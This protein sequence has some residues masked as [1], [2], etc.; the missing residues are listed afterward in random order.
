MPNRRRL[1]K[2]TLSL[3]ASFALTL[4]GCASISELLNPDPSTP[5]TQAQPEQ[6]SLAN[7]PTDPAQT[8]SQ[9]AKASEFSEVEMVWEISQQPVD[10]YL[11]RYGFSRD[12]LDKEI[13]VST[14]V[15]NTASDPQFGT[16]YKY[17]LKGIPRNESVFVSIAAENEGEL[18]APSEVFEVPPE[19]D[20]APQ[21]TPAG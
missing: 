20:P 9:A 1:H 13:R 16:V 7:S 5:T 8:S 14:Q 2:I 12:N 15:L 18:S 19:Q 17:T 6:N 10:R 3:L 21:P 11:I 4:G